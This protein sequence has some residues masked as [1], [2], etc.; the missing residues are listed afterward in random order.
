MISILPAL[1]ACYFLLVGVVIVKSDKPSELIKIFFAFCFTTFVWQSSFAAMFQA[2][3]ERLALFL[4]KLGWSFILFLPTTLYHFLVLLNQKKEDAQMVRCS[5]LLSLLLLFFLLFS[6]LLLAGVT[7]HSWGYYPKAG[8]FEIIHII[9]TFVIV[10]RGLVITYRR[11]VLL[12]NEFLKKPQTYYCFFGFFVYLLAAID[13]LPNYGF[14]I[15][16]LGVVFI[17][18]G[19][20]IIMAAKYQALDLLLSESYKIAKYNMMTLGVVGLIGH[21]LYWAIWTYVFPQRYDSFAI[22]LSAALLCAVFL[23]YKNFSKRFEKYLPIFWFLC[24][25]YA[26]PFLFTVHLI[27]NNFSDIWLMCEVGMGFMIVIFMPDFLLMLLNILLGVI[28]AIA[29]CTIIPYVP[30]M[31]ETHHIILFEGEQ[32]APIFLFVLTAGHLFNY[33]SILGA[34]FEE[35]VIAEQKFLALKSLAATIAHE[36]RNPF[37]AMHLAAKN[38]KDAIN[39]IITEVTFNSKSFSKDTLSHISNNCKEISNNLDISLSAI[40]RGSNIIDVTLNEISDQK[41]NSA[42]FVILNIK[43]VVEKAV[44]EYGYSSNK[45]RSRVINNIATE[46][47]FTFKGDENLMIYVLFNLIKNALY[48][49]NTHPNL[50]ITIDA[51]SRHNSNHQETS[52]DKKYNYLYVRDNGCGVPLDVLPHLFEDFMTANKREGTGLGLAFCKRTMKAFGGDITCQS[53][54]KEYTEFELAF[55]M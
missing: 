19:L 36:M 23:F 52:S 6:D 37:M 7:K 45:E 34:K 35:K 31:S 15:Y 51:E 26:L 28:L 29:F 16:P 43:D 4:A 8:M 38:S 10:S 55:P 33:G 49:S 25:S 48:Y 14:A 40:K 53:Q 9:Q 21:P 50:T 18:T 27:R 20:T 11:Q 1:V 47:N 39:E 46:N 12:D 30:V 24:V 2:P 13:Y 54:L 42:N 3:N 17:V 5:Y 32:Y 44:K 22:R 41:V